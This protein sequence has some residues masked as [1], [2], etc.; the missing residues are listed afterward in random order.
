MALFR[1][2]RRGPCQQDGEGKMIHQKL[3]LPVQ[4]AFDIH[5]E[6]GSAA[7]PTAGLSASS[8]PTLAARRDGLALFLL[9]LTYATLRYQVGKGVPWADWPIYTVNKALGVAVLGLIAVGL[10]RVV[11]RRITR[12]GEHFALAGQ[13]M[14][15]HCVLSLA[16][17]QPAYFPKFFAEGKLTGPASLA[18]LSGVAAL[19]AFRASRTQAQRWSLEN[20]MRV[21]GA[22]AFTAGLHAALPGTGTWLA[23]EAWPLNLPPITLI[24]FIVGI[25][26]ACLPW[27]RAR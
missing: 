21:A 15:A 11:A 1:L 13:A 2:G 4:E 20:R 24:A 6:A 14:V 12:L 18:L 22:I 19:I 16:L 5:T 10:I 23:F 17:L 7:A 8:D 26:T 27:L 3:P 25:C 9:A